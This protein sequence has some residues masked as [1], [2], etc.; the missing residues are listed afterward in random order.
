MTAES[1]RES[2]SILAE[3]EYG[4]PMRALWPLED[5]ALYL[6]HGTVGVTPLEI[7][8]AQWEIKQR[9]EALPAVICGGS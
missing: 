9:I 4:H 8:A 1:D 2:D 3:Y 7:L 5:G 6:N